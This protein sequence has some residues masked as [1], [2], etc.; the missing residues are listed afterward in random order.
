MVSFN[1]RNQLYL[2]G[3]QAALIVLLAYAPAHAQHLRGNDINLRNY[4]EQKLHYGF[5]LGLNFSRF[6]FQTQDRYAAS[7]TVVQ[8]KISP[9]FSLG[10]LGV[11]H[12]NPWWEM[13][14]APMASFNERTLEYTSLSDGNTV[15]KL[16]EA[17]YIDVPL[18][19]RF[20]SSRRGNARMFMLIGAGA[21][22]ALA[23]KVEEEDLVRVKPFDVAIEFGFGME[24]FFP[25]FKFAPELRF[26]Q[27][28]M[29]VL[30]QDGNAYSGQLKALYNQRVSLYFFFE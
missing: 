10:L 19:F 20:K 2:L 27:G 5:V 28:I 24:K 9:G 4:D 29:N 6:H 14:L 3:C 21:S 30:E 18:L 7:D 13:R 22:F 23:K 1:I 12:L 11:L 26:S 15:D 17:T 25:M 8:T 16:V